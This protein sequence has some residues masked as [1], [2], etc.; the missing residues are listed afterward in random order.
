MFQNALSK[1]TTRKNRLIPN[2]GLF[3]LAA[4]LSMASAPVLE[5]G[6]AGDE[7][8]LELDHLIGTNMAL[9]Y[10]PTDLAKPG[11]MKYLKQWSPGLIRLPGGSWSNEYYWNGNGVRTG[12]NTFDESKFQDGK[13][14]I[15]YSDYAPG[16]RVHGIEQHLSDYHGVIDVR[17]QHELAESLGAD[18]MVTVN[19]G[20][21]TPEMA[22]EWLK[23]TNESGYSV[24]YWEIGNELNGQWE[25]GHFLPDGSRMTGEI[26]ARLFAEYARALKA[27]DP[28]V[29]VGGPASS[30][31]NLAFIEEL[32]RDAGDL[33]DFIS[34]HAYPVGVQQT[35]TAAKFADIDLLREALATIRGWKKQYQPD[36]YDNIE[37]AITEWNMK[38]NE[39]RDTADLI[40]ALW[41][42]AWIGAMLEGEVTLSNQWDLLTRTAEGGHGA[43][44]PGE[45]RIIPTALYWAHT[46]WG[47]FMGDRVVEHSTVDS[48]LLESFVTGSDSG[49]PDHADQSVRGPD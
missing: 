18:Q 35:E 9:W 4:T 3:M 31:L 27:E 13:W 14:N 17:K 46:L 38:V 32:L 28:S 39:D 11:F 33:V 8:T 6:P 16:F 45:D 23:W 21:G 37:I 40:N 26:Y 47:N 42:A 12:P 15:D 19:V 25:V 30:D 10:E 7:A 34:F 29:K 2:V 44:Y 24:P 20:T 5:I 36:R 49:I 43:F 1:M 48:G 22:A 41:C